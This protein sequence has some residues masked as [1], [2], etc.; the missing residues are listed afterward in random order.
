MDCVN[1][2]VDFVIEAWF[3][4]NLEAK[5]KAI[6]LDGFVSGLP[7]RR[8]GLF[9]KDLNIFLVLVKIQML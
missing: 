7:S 2:G 6:N 5:L 3:V 8:N 9:T 1:D 4:G